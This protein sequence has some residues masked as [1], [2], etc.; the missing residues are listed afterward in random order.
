[1]DTENYLFLSP[2]SSGGSF[3]FAIAI[4]GNEQQ[5]SAPGLPSGEWVHVA[6]TL[7]GNSGKLFVN[8]APV[9]SNTSMTHNPR[10]AAAG[11]RVLFLH[12]GAMDPGQALTGGG[13]SAADVFR[14]LE[15]L[16]I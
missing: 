2:R 15:E 6:V 7:A 8:G 13:F 16:G 5:I 4:N 3:R 9:G 10:D 12:D 14:R 1:M 11:D